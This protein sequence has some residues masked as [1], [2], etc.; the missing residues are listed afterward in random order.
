[1]LLV[2]DNPDVAGATMALLEQLG[3]RVRFVPD[4][5][6][7]L[8]EL[9]RRAFKLVVTDIV[10]PGVMDGLGLA[11]TIRQQ[12]PEM[13][14]ILVSGYSDAAGSADKEFIVLRKPYQAAELSRAIAHATAS[15]KALAS[16]LLPFRGGNGSRS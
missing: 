12:H 4:A 13:P 2:E 11:R 7:A 1:M 10:M 14:L 16:N 9:K 15:H 3:Y 5:S 6:A 8:E